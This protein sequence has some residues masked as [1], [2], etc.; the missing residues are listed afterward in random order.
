MNEPPKPYSSD[1]FAPNCNSIDVED[2]EDLNALMLSSDCKVSD[3]DDEE[4][5]ATPIVCVCCQEP[6][7]P[8]AFGTLR[9]RELRKICKVCHGKSISAARSKN[10]E[11]AAVEEKPIVQA[12]RSAQVLVKKE[13]KEA[14]E[15][16][17][18]EIGKVAIMELT[19][20]HSALAMAYER[21]KAEGKAFDDLTVTEVELPVI[22]DEVLGAR[23]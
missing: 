1:N 12:D 23:V 4:E 18:K 21:G 10:K 13:F 20:F 17:P 16:N 14:V 9:N 15:T 22:L 8:D 5:T 3:I 6:K 7:S 2:M 19:V 11:T